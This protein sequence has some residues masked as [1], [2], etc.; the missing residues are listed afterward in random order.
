MS[1][2]Q[3]FDKIIKHK[4]EEAEFPFDEANWTKANKMLDAEKGV[5]AGK[6]AKL[7]MLA[8]A[9][10]L[11]L[12]TGGFF[13]YKY[14]EGTAPSTET[15]ENKHSENPASASDLKIN[16][17]S[18][19]I[20]ESDKK[21]L[22]DNNHTQSMSNAVETNAGKKSA[23]KTKDRQS[24]N[25]YNDSELGAISNS[26]AERKTNTMSTS[27]KDA[28]VV[29]ATDAST[30]NS[31][32][33]TATA[34]NSSP[35]MTNSA[36]TN[37][38]KDKNVIVKS[39]TAKPT[40]IR[41]PIGTSQPKG[42]YIDN[43]TSTPSM[44]ETIFVSDEND[45][46]IF[47]PLMK[48]SVL[49][50]D[51]FSLR[52]TPYDFIRI[53]EDDYYKS[54]RKRKTHFMNVEAG[55]AYMLGWNVPVGKDAKGF[56]T[57]A[58]INYGLH[59]GKRLSASV[60]AQIYNI[61]NIEQPFYTGS[62]VT[63]GFGSNGTYTSVASNS[64]YYFAIPAKVN[65]VLTKHDHIGVG[66]NT[67]FLFNGMNTVE[68]YEMKDGVKSNESKTRYS[69]YFEGT[70]TTNIML[71]ASYGHSFTKRMRVNAEFMYGISDT[72]KNSVSSETKENNMGIRLGVQYT[73]FDK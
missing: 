42:G 14:F 36:G 60:G 52:K 12:G 64:L 38:N 57:Y 45:Y 20:T 35:A 51:S 61:G 40:G 33:K 18:P 48:L 70:N 68:T 9:V 25:S 4:I 23:D 7:F 39:K 73:L 53:Y 6:S 24:V 11:M 15:S 37:L 8:A 26:N 13:T 17:A 62:N 44:E 22:A 5:S 69:G 43:E 49:D 2:E 55:M 65:F 71:S 58:G 21:E 63:Y 46:R 31:S 3:K 56:N 10:L 59:L 54:V 1:F 67:G 72:Y 66:V 30:D 50:V 47:A 29:P 16:N 28:K 27:G 19:S 41:Y 34:D 32:T